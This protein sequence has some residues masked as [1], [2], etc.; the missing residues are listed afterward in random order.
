MHGAQ[1][2]H[3][4]A[5]TVPNHATVR[6]HPAVSELHCEGVAVPCDLVQAGAPA[7]LPVLGWGHGSAP[8]PSHHLWPP[9]PP[10]PPSQQLL[11]WSTSLEMP[12]EGRPQPRPPRKTRPP[13]RARPPGRRESKLLSR[14]PKLPFL[15][16]EIHPLSRRR[17]G[18]LNSCGARFCNPRSSETAE[19]SQ[20]IEKTKELNG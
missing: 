20:L 2:V 8:S 9:V 11:I 10:Q 3:A 1:L 18:P 15:G 12:W 7:P 6:L 5:A 17:L 19:K 16:S 14:P 4:G 13:L